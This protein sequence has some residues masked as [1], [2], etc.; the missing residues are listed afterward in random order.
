MVA[1]GSK[2]GRITLA[3]VAG[4]DEIDDLVTDSSADAQELDRIA[5]LGVAIHVVDLV[6]RPSESG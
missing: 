1:D 2:V 5:A 4:L 3:R 6:E